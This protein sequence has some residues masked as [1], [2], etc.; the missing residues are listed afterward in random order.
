MTWLLLAA[1]TVAACELLRQI[2]FGRLQ[3]RFRD[4]AGR[5]R[6]VMGSARISD[7]W[8]QRMI[9]VYA[10]RMARACLWLLALIVLVFAPFL[11]AAM[12]MPGGLGTLMAVLLR[13]AVSLSL[14]LGSVAYL[15]LRARLAPASAGTEQASNYSATDRFL[16]RVALGASPLAEV[17]HDIEKA[18]FLK[19]A[20]QARDGAHVFVC[21]LARAGT[22]VLTRELHRSG[23][24]GSLTY[25][26]MPFV[27]APNLWSAVS[28]SSSLARKER[29]HGD[30][31][32]VD[33]DSPEALDEV[34]W[35]LTSGADYIGADALRPHQPDADALEG[36]ETLIRLVLL[37]TG[38]ARYLAKNNNNI[39]R[40]APLAGHFPRA[41]FLVPIRAPLEHAR[42]LMRQHQRF[43]RVAGFDR[44]YVAWLGH[45]EFGA[46]HLPF[47]FGGP[48]AGSPE[49]LDYWLQIWIDVYR[50]LRG[51]VAGLA[52]QACFVPHE[53]LAADSVYQ[54]GLM[55]WLGVEM[56]ALDELR[57][58]APAAVAESGSA[59]ALEA[60]ALYDEIVGNQAA[61]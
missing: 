25:R 17:V 46:T 1:A 11:V 48:P 42:S 7:H 49:E 24:F 50:H 3:S 16:H 32:E 2:P 60:A 9:P 34:Y 10:F 20:P 54:A 45:H 33:L 21:G 59:R 61:A 14:L 30:G 23:A 36:Y 31:L 4:T 37:K 29:S 55:R 47:A 52:G 12:L 28:R 18:R 8:K 44:Q 6:R 51:T 53:R 39:L 19:R 27:M 26:D 22:T 38:K 13:P 5:I 43:A 57:P 41:R 56:P 35:R 15:W 40:L 58:R